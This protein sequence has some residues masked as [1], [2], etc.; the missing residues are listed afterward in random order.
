M[1]SLQNQLP[2][3]ESSAISSTNSFETSNGV[4]FYKSVSKPFTGNSLFSVGNAISSGLTVFTSNVSLG[5][6]PM[7]QVTSKPILRPT[8]KNALNMM[9]D[10]S[11][12]IIQPNDPDD[13]TPPSPQ[14]CPCL[15]Y[16]YINPSQKVP[17]YPSTVRN[18]FTGQNMY[19]FQMENGT[20]SQNYQSLIFYDSLGKKISQGIVKVSPGFA[21]S[22]SP[23]MPNSN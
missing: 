7:P 6:L 11:T 2:S 13:P 20:L 10:G 9:P 23:F 16:S 1:S 4:K 17:I 5:S 18:N 3:T 19:T 8:P 22:K 21:L 12:S 14:D 15:E